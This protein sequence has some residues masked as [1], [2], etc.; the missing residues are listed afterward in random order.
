M[1]RNF[2]RVSVVIL[3]ACFL[4]ISISNLAFGQ[5]NASDV[6]GRVLDPKG[7]AVVDADVLLTNDATGD[8]RAT[9]TTNIGEFVFATVQPGT[10]TLSIKAAGFKEREQKG[11]QV[12][13]SSRYSAGDLKLEIGAVKETVT[14]EANATP[15]QTDSGERSALLDST[16]VTNLMSRGRDIMALLTILPGVVQDTEGSDSLGTFKSPTAMSGTRGD[17]NSMNMDGI[18]GNPRS[19][20]NLDTPL[21]MDAISEVKVLQNSYQAEYGKGAGSIINVVS[22]SGGRTFHGAAYDY[23]RNEAF[24]ARDWFSF[25]SRDKLTGALPPKNQYRYETFGYNL[26]GPIFIPGH[27]N[28]NREKAFFFFSQEILQNKQPN[29]LRKFTVPTD[30]ERRGDFSAD[31]NGNTSGV[32]KN[33][34]L[35]DPGTCG[36]AGNMLC[37]LTGPGIK[38]TINPAAIDPNF[39]AILKMYPQPLPGMDETFQAL[40]G[41]NY[42]VQDVQSRPVRQEILRIDYNFTN[43]LKMFVR[44]MNLHTHN[45]G[46][47]ATTNK[48]T[49]SPDTA[50]YTIT[51]PNVGGTIT[52]IINPTLVNEFT[53]GWAEWRE[54]YIVPAK[55][56]TDLLR[57]TVGFN[58]G[59]IGSGGLPTSVTNPLGAVPAVSY[60]GSNPPTIGY[61]AR[62]PLNDNAYTWTYSD[63]ISKLWGNHQFKAGIQTERATYWQL[64]TG[65]SSFAGTYDF[66]TGGT[67]DLGQPFANALTGNFK[68]YSESLNQ[69]NYAPVTRILE[70]YVQDTWKV[71]P[72]LTLDI[73]ARFTAGLPQI[74]RQH[75]AAT[76]DQSLYNFATAPQ[77]FS[78]AK[79]ANSGAGANMAG[80]VGVAVGTRAAYNPITKSICDPS[81][82]KIN[83]IAIIG[84]FVPPG[85]GPN[86]DGIVISGVNG[87]PNGLVDFQGVYVAPRFGFA[88]DVFGDGKTSLRGGLGVNY[89]P[90]Q[91]SGILGDTDATPPL[92]NT[93]QQF[94][95]SSLAGNGAY[96]GLPRYQSPVNIPRILLR[97]SGQPVAYNASIGIQR[98]IGYGTV[99]DVAYVGSFGRHMGQLSEINQVPYGVRYGFVDTANPGTPLNSPGNPLNGYIVQPNFISDNQIRYF[100]SGY[101]GYG[102]TPVLTF[103]GNSSYHS[104]QSQINHRFSHGM[105][106]GGSWTWSKAM[107]YNDAGTGSA[108]DKSNIVVN[109]GSPKLYNYGLAAYDRTHVVAINYL[110]DLPRASRLWDSTFSRIMLDG[111]QVA[112]ITRFSAGAPLYWNGGGGNA[113]DQFMGSGNLTYTGSLDNSKNIKDLTGGGDGW[114]PI[115]IADPHLS[116]GDRNYYHYFNPNAFTLPDTIDCSTAPANNNYTAGPIAYCHF[117]HGIYGNTGPNVLGRGPGLGNFNMS[118]FKNFKVG[119]RWNIQF[120]AEAY[121]V[122]N[123]AQFDG[124]NTTPKFDQ[125]G[126]LTN[127]LVLG[128]SGLPTTTDWFGRINSSRD[129]RILQFALRITF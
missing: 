81:T 74:P 33:L 58:Y 78:D 6:T 45:N 37:L 50:D 14:V 88:Y 26:G 111:W 126:N 107:D 117:A 13:S 71:L 122:F 39:L 109:A 119:E 9:K 1:Q 16:Q 43:N 98:E 83:P 96:L 47:T 36:T 86:P 79:G 66:S 32:P 29:G 52:W 65:S 44:G 19:G 87:Y 128:A 57:S 104:L 21:N 112:G 80:C 68:S 106:F 53:L 38:N 121:N 73:G 118:M 92:L 125:F 75:Q 10:Y 64:H 67:N 42:T 60:G 72:R 63:G 77:L 70:W 93:V 5:S 103:T 91:G 34:T 28:T 49:W 100:G 31:F 24:N 84:Q 101:A 15:V 41:Y 123:H 116:G 55:S 85:Y 129:P 3:T 46:V 17:Y 124:V 30:R 108:A 4:I 2:L 97:N 82:G 18:S 89:N 102:N 48:N 94:N 105:Q 61:D 20:Q 59:M 8:V 27:F 62:W 113:S 95:G 110:I 51:G 7:Q 56:L 90:R 76:L 40:N 120:R 54:H 114:R 23:L 12:S 22:K 69:T 115:I 127:G 99:V 11:L 35:K 25:E